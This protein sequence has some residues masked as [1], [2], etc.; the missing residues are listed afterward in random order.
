M[1]QEPG[2][3][4]GFWGRDDSSTSFSVSGTTGGKTSLFD[5]LLPGGDDDDET[6]EQLSPAAVLR[7]QRRQQH[8]LQQHLAAEPVF[9]L[10]RLQFGRQQVVESIPVRL[11]PGGAAVF[12]EQ[13][14]FTTKRPLQNKQLV[15]EVRVI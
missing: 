1:L 6:D 11:R 10:A 2:D 13:F 4:A 9:A 15:M 5:F 12:R 7:R 8:L 14:V 3:E